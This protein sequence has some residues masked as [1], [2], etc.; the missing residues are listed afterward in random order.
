MSLHKFAQQPSRDLRPLHQEDFSP[1][2]PLSRSLISLG[3]T[4]TPLNIL[5]NIPVV[6]LESNMPIRLSR[7]VERLGELLQ[8]DSR[9]IFSTEPQN[10]K[11]GRQRLFEFQTK[12]LIGK[13]GG[14]P[15]HDDLIDQGVTQLRFG[16]DDARHGQVK[17][18]LEG[19][20]IDASAREFLLTPLSAVIEHGSLSFSARTALVHVQKNVRLYD[21]QGGETMVG[22]N[23]A[24]HASEMK[25]GHLVQFD[26]SKSS[27]THSF[28]EPILNV[29]M[30]RQLC[31]GMKILPVLKDLGIEQVTPQLKLNLE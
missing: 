1:T 6:V 27:T 25:I 11:D 2:Q 5:K 12:T 8:L 30:S 21:V 29:L 7:G 3:M 18:L 14:K 15:S 19:Q 4:V 26:F 31:F 20:F 9:D 23:K 13:Y 24:G 17:E 28:V 10:L 22:T 16:G